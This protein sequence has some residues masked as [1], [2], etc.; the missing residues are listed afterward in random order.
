MG[1]PRLWAI[2]DS[3]GPLNAELARRGIPAIGTETTGRAGCRE[4]DVLSYESGL[5]N[6]LAYLQIVRDHP[7]P[8]RD[9]QP[10]KTSVEVTASVASFVQ[11]TV[12][13]GQRVHREQQLATVIDVFGSVIAKV[14]SPVDGEIWAA[15]ESPVVDAGDLLFMVAFDS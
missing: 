2:P 13:L 15:L 5:W 4:V 10:A 6:L 12:Q 7:V 14:C 1:L 9:F 8:A 3:A 11:V